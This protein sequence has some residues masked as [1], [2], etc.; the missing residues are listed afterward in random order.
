[1]TRWSETDLQ[2]LMT[3]R[4]T[5]TA[6]RD[7][8]AK[9]IPRE[10]LAYRGM[11][12]EKLL[13]NAN[14]AYFKAGIAFVY[15]V[16]TASRVIRRD[17]QVIQLQVPSCVDYLGT[18]GGRALAQEA[19]ETKEARWPLSKIEDHQVQFLMDWD[20]GGGIAG[21]LIHFSGHG[22]TFWLPIGELLNFTERSVR[23]GRK[24]ISILELGER[25]MVPKTARAEVDYLVT[26]ERE[27][28][29]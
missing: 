23:G 17:D 15:K 13:N 20:R 7:S 4:Q 12:F 3:R 25:W 26:I 6:S 28:M 8:T 21:I 27:C 29:R 22:R 19:K 2:T 16:P 10:N 11:G 1:M 14:E 9:A 18:W 5:P 24:S